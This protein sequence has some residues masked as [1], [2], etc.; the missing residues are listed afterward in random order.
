MQRSH[1]T[2]LVVAATVI[3]GGALLYYVLKDSPEQQAMQT[4]TDAAGGDAAQDTAGT[5]VGTAADAT[6]EGGG[7]DA[8][9][10]E[11]TASGG[12]QPSS[13][14]DSDGSTQD[15]AAQQQ[16]SAPVA[17]GSEAQAPVPE[18]TEPAQQREVE[19]PGPVA[20]S[21]DVVRVEPS[22]DTVI[23]GRAEPGSKVTVLDNGKPLGSVI[24]D[25]NGEW[26]FLS[27]KPLSPGN[28][29]LSLESEGQDGLKIPSE[30]VV[31]MS[32]PETQQTEAA[33]EAPIAVL[34]PRAGSGGSQVLQA[35]KGEGIAEGD[36][37]LE[38]VDYG[39]DGGITVSGRATPESTI[40][41]YLDNE[42]LGETVT[43]SD[44]RWS[45]TVAREVPFGIY[46]LRADLVTSEGEV[47]A[48]VE[49]PFSRVEFAR[50]SLPDEKFVIVQPGN[51]LWRIA[52]GTL[53]EGVRYSVIYQAN[54]DQI[55]DPD[56]IYPGQIFVVPQT[57]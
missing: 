28:R 44:G 15:S 23:A 50:A 2:S 52:R 35:P 10:S 21:F 11:T 12:A 20:P 9:A 22:G 1:L 18:D 24:A 6:A 39:D 40:R 26:V 3:L 30:D 38:A 32:V 16:A 49:T 51:S 57:N 47:L 7:Q 34:A 14:D 17:S 54:Q 46:Q 48:R 8:P 55:R 4:A 5:A 56:L 45:Y 43:D 27:E 25:D 31:V 36:L 13:S 53:G 41:L 37:V 29:E 33:A 42:L 19:A